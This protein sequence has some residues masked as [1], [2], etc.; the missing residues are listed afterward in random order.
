MFFVLQPCPSWSFW[1]PWRQCSVTCGGGVQTRE[2]TCLNG[3]AGDTGCDG[4]AS[5]SVPC[6]TGVS[7]CLRVWMERV[8][9]TIF[10][11]I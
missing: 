4:S 3:E 6:N 5:D 1:T 10:L 8:M 2:R 7:T 9:P 11:W